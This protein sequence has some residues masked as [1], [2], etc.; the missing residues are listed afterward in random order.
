MNKIT[1]TNAN[2]LLDEIRRRSSEIAATTTP[3]VNVRTS[4]ATGCMIGEL[5]DIDPIQEGRSSSVSLRIIDVPSV[6]A[7]LKALRNEASPAVKRVITAFKRCL[8]VA[9]ASAKAEHLAL[10]GENST[11]IIVGT[12]AA[13]GRLGRRLCVFDLHDLVCV[14]NYMTDFLL[15]Q[16]SETRIA[17]GQSEGDEFYT[18]FPAL[19]DT[20]SVSTKSMY[21]IVDGQITHR[22]RHVIQ[23]ANGGGVGVF[24]VLP[25]L[26]SHLRNL[27]S[28][29]VTRHNK[30][31][32]GATR[33][34]EKFALKVIDEI[35]NEIV[36]RTNDL[37]SMNLHLVVNREDIDYT[38]PTPPTPSEV[39][40]AFEPI[41]ETINV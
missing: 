18:T 26:R 21:K 40:Q 11:N 1:S 27:D 34:F 5:L 33:H 2:E 4:N 38:L 10:I 39:A 28:T 35:D 41:E 6:E 23:I 20:V 31:L 29:N 14:H 15:N 17:Y 30:T 8:N 16:S 9:K 25:L 22:H 24:S 19:P 36:A 13:T 37:A 3:V 12:R 32:N 7:Q